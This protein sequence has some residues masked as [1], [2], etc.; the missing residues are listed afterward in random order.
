[1]T[2]LFEELE[3]T[4]KSYYKIDLRQEN[5]RRDY[6]DSRRIFCKIAFEFLKQSKTKIGR[7]LNFDHSTVIHYLKGFNGI[8]KSDKIFKSNY[9]NILKD[10]KILHPHVLLLQEKAKQE[11]LKY[12]KNIVKLLETQLKTSA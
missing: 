5:R 7:Y 2:Y 6:I 1:M 8:L 9:E 10:F 12:Y 11:Q 4:I 3:H